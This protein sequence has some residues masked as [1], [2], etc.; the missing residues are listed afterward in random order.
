[1][2]VMIN[3]IT[4]VSLTNGA[5]LTL[6]APL[7]V[8]SGGTETTTLT[9]IL[10]GN[11]TSAI[12]TAVAGTDYL[13]PAAIGV[14]I[15]A[16]NPN[17]LTTAAIGTTIQAYDADLAAFATKTAPTGAVVGTTDTQTLTSKTITGLRETRVI[18]TGNNIDL[19]TGNYFTK[20]ITASTT[21]TLSNVPAAGTVA[22]FILDLTDGSSSLITWWA[23]L[24]W[25]AGVAPTLTTFGRDTLGFFTHDG[26]A[27]WTGFILGK[28]IK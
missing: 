4:G 17:I 24:K 27:T 19:S 2:T 15:Q 11:G 22:S 10:L 6:D 21:F 23:N 8:E 5:T 13:A 18:L 3:G 25:V 26:G 9:G 16:Y 7:P 14:T 20:T 1:M 12:G 28:D